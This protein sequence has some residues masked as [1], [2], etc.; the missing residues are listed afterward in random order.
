LREQCA[1]RAGPRPKRPKPSENKSHCGS[2]DK[3][4]DR[5][6]G[7]AAAR[8][9]PT[10]RSRSSGTRDDRPEDSIETRHTQ[11]SSIR[12]VSFA[13]SFA[14]GFGVSEEIVG[15][16]FIEVVVAGVTSWRE[17]FLAGEDRRRADS[18]EREGRLIG[19]DGE[20][21]FSIPHRM[22][23]ETTRDRHVYRILRV[24]HPGLYSS[25]RPDNRLDPWK[26]PSKF[27]EIVDD[28]CTENHFAFACCRIVA[29]NT[30]LSRT[31]WVYRTGGSRH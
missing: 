24:D 17:R 5:L 6:L 2:A 4:S 1:P 29:N 26:P 8:A 7:A 15:R 25:R 18:T 9:L 10:P 12:P 13:C 31:R 20:S 22:S 23:G 19:Y 30:R 27:R 21:I 3:Y 28:Y 14:Q 11:R 16:L